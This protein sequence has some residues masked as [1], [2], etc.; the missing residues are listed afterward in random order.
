MIIFL[1]G[2][3][4]FRSRQKL[5]E[6]K[7]KFLREVDP[8]G[9]SLSALDGSI[10]T[11][12]KINESV[13]PSSFFSKKR[14]V[15]VENIFSNKA[16]PFFGQLAEFFKKEKNRDNIIV[17]R[18]SVSGAEK[19]PK[20]KAELFALLAKQK[21]AQE[22]KLLSNVEAVKWV[23]KETEA[24]GGK[25]NASA[26]AELISLLGSDLWLINSEIDK[27]INYKA[28]QKLP[29]DGQERGT[30]IEAEDV[31]N[32]ARGVFDENI[33]ALTDA[34]SA[35][36]KK[37]AA[38]LLEEQIEGGMAEAY[39]LTMIIRQFRI[40]LQIRQALD[41]GETSG[42]ISGLLKIH[43]YVAQKGISQARGFSLVELKKIFK[44]LTEI[45]YLMKTGQADIKTTLSV[46]L[47]KI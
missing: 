11:L 15:V 27:L 36:N 43:P 44:R 22:F 8:T 45:D 10:A 47:M 38:E 42:K 31:K 9:G 26:A 7:E 3:D 41:L 14:M 37:R 19:L 39:L 24:R 12:E 32:L 25:I 6:L 40:L 20:Y 23:K 29:I 17:F 16:Q 1:Y 33:F 21:Y 13:S 35:K 2:E 46:L 28:G 18:D 30:I 4:T 5:N 34:W